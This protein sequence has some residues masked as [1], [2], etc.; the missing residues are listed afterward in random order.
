MAEGFPFRE[1]INPCQPDGAHSGARFTQQKLD[2]QFL[3][4][5]CRSNQRAECPTRHAK[6]WNVEYIFLFYRF[7]QV[8][9]L[10]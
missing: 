3:P 5:A 4:A 6:V 7:L 9:D 10:D 1:R 2:Q 8:P